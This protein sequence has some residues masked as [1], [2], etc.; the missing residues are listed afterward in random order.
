MKN[1]IKIAAIY[2]S[3]F[4]MLQLT[5]N[6]QMDTLR[7]G[8]RVPNFY[9]WDTN[10]WDY[11]YIN[12]TTNANT[13][14]TYD[15]ISIGAFEF[16]NTN[17]RV[18]CARYCYV[19]KELYIIGVAGVV[20]ITMGDATL[21]SLMPEYFRVYE[22]GDDSNENS[23]FL[24]AEA[25]WDTFT[26][27]HMMVVE[28]YYRPFYWDYETETLKYDT[29]EETVLPV[30][31]AYFDHPVPVHDSFYVSGTRENT[32]CRFQENNQLGYITNF[33]QH[34]PSAN[35]VIGGPINCE[36]RMMYYPKPP[37]LKKKAHLIDTLYN[38]SYHDTLWHGTWDFLSFIYLFPIFDTNNGFGGGTHTLDTCMYPSGF[39][40]NIPAYGQGPVVLLWNDNG[41]TEQ[42]ELSLCKECDNP[43]DG[44]ISL[45]TI[46]FASYENLDTATW[47]T[48]WIRA[49]CDSLRT[50]E[51]SD[52]L[53]FFV[54]GKTGQGSETI[55]DIV[56]QYTSVMPN[57]AHGSVTVISSF[58]IRNIDIYTLNGQLAARKENI[59]AL[60]SALS[61]HTLPPST[62]LLRIQTSHGVAYKKLVVK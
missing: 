17:C 54:P 39:R 36:D 38:A 29:V 5:C 62:Y 12:Y 34:Y 33:Y 55:S 6:A 52:S 40:A 42:W 16:G 2:L 20:Y 31:E 59:N 3:A 47:Y 13:P 56:D 8:D 24:L 1:T 9:Y 19:E 14:P 26:P 53:R 43:D 25:R 22:V 41:S 18:E 23:M 11:Y 37:H 28:E 48:A 44:T 30:Y 27:R 4:F 61:L 60:S 45:H 10:W 15:R 58:N 50:S 57:P 7:T 51:W 21:D 32:F 35:Y 46:N 49:H